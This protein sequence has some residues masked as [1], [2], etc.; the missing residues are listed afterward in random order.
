MKYRKATRYEDFEAKLLQNPE[1]RR[2]Y[3]VL[4]PKYDM[5]RCLIER[6]NQLRVSQ[7]ELATAIGT[8]QPAISRLERGDSNTTIDTLFKVTNALDLNVDIS[9]KSVQATKLTYDKVPA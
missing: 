9:P 3:E 7:A 5:I 2:E 4:E 1:I 8:K 6:R